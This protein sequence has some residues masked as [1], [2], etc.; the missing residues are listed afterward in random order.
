[1]LQ[2]LLG[3]SILEQFLVERRLG[4]GVQ[5]ARDTVQI[6]GSE[7]ALQRKAVAVARLHGHVVAVAGGRGGGQAPG[8]KL[9]AVPAVVGQVQDVGR[10][11]GAQ[12]ADAEPLAG[13]VDQRVPVAATA[14]IFQDAFPSAHNLGQV[15]VHRARAHGVWGGAVDT[16]GRRRGT[17][18]GGGLPPVAQTWAGAGW[19][20]SGEDLFVAHSSEGTWD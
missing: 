1:M 14:R 11:V 17:A 7:L 15:H 18:G 12:A 20:E 4:A 6:E 10:G 9:L 13:V 8:G 16:R 2:H 19:L 5:A 3:V